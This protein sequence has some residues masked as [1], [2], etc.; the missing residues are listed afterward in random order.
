M[1]VVYFCLQISWVSVMEVEAWLERLRKLHTVQ[2]ECC[3]DGVAEARNRRA[4]QGWNSTLVLLTSPV[5]EFLLHH[6]P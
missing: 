3:V 5:E 2:H 4:S 6:L 1:H